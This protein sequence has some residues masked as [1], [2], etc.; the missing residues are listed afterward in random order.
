MVSSRRDLW[1]DVAEHRPILKNNQNTYLSF[2][3]TPKTG[4]ELLIKGVSVLLWK[5]NLEGENINNL[6]TNTRLLR[7]GDKQ[8]GYTYPLIENEH[9]FQSL[10]SRFN[11]KIDSIERSEFGL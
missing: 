8:R 9:F 10:P 6:A 1:N 11:H 4:I 2:S 3:F 5:G 7:T